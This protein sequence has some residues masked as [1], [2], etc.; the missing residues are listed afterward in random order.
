MLGL[1][2]QTFLHSP[3]IFS[4]MSL[5]TQKP[6]SSADVNW[7]LRDCP[8]PS[9]A[10]LHQLSVAWDIQ[11]GL[12]YAAGSSCLTLLYPLGAFVSHPRGQMC[13]TITRCFLTSHKNASC[14]GIG[15]KLKA[16]VVFANTK[17]NSASFT[18]EAQG[19]VSLQAVEP[20]EA[21]PRAGASVGVGC[22]PCPR[23]LQ[24]PGGQED[25]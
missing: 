6:G 1:F 10:A 8:Q 25:H 21:S 17:H 7:P 19:L 12:Q 4:T 16:S 2:S 9:H 14:A 20:G 23:C 22:H 15:E 5:M 11:A 18:G 24:A 13:F 3:Q